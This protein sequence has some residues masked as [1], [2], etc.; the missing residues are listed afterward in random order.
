MKSMYKVDIP[1][2]S[3]QN[4]DILVTFGFKNCSHILGTFLAI[5]RVT[6]SKLTHEN[7]QNQGY[8]LK[9]NWRKQKAL[10]QQ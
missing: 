2:P 7:K 9:R 4:Q 1:D 10:Q 8:K 5:K 6:I 3:S